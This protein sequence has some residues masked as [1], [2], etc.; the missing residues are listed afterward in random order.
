MGKDY[1]NTAILLDSLNKQDLFAFDFVY[2]RYRKKLFIVAFYIL[3]DEEMNK[4]LI[5]EFFLDF[6]DNRLYQ[7]ISCTLGAYL[8]SAIRNRAIN[9]KRKSEYLKEKLQH[10]Y[11]DNIPA[12]RY[13]LENEELKKRLHAVIEKLPPMSGRVFRMHYI[14]QSNYNEISEQLG[15]TKSTI[16]NHIGRALQELRASLKK[17]TEI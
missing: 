16:G 13:P 5:H 4:D 2:T 10:G 12:V 9:L 6:W 14:D 3:R 17:E 11:A 15:I 8:S 7:K 1:N